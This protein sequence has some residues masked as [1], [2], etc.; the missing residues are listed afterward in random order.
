MSLERMFFEKVAAIY[1]AEEEKQLIREAKS[2]DIS[3]WRQLRYRFKG[4]IKK[5]V[6][7]IKGSAPNIPDDILE[8]QAMEEFERSVNAYD[9]SKG[10]QP[11]TFIS[12]NVMLNLKKFRSKHAYGARQSNA[13]T[14]LDRLMHAPRVMFEREHGRA[15]TPEEMQQQLARMGHAVQA[16]NIQRVENYKRNEWSANM[17]IGTEDVGDNITFRDVM[18]VDDTSVED[19]LESQLLGERIDRAI[20][21]LTPLEQKL[22]REHK[23]I[24]GVRKAPSLTA[25]AF[26]NNLPSAW[27][28]QKKLKAISEKLR[29]QLSAP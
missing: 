14:D 4:M 10:A 18:D 13:N 26:N 21:T 2:G 12:Q 8:A 27:E 29:Q 7:Q 28:A 1:N 15:P 23:G 24:G 25:L 17:T 11:N 16:R 20:A 6:N 5:I 9:E 19:L 3:A 22:Y